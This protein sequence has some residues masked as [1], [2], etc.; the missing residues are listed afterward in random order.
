MRVMGY[1][2]FSGGFVLLTI[3][4]NID[5]GN[6][7]FENTVISDFCPCTPYAH[8]LENPSHYI[9]Y[10]VKIYSNMAKLSFSLFM[11]Q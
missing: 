5:I 11:D 3:N 1:F 7:E 2:Y 6:N 4:I 9:V 8:M 10:R